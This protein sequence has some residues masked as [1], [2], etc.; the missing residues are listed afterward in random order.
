MAEHD[1]RKLFKLSELDDFRVAKGDPDIRGWRLVDGTHNPIG[2][3]KELIADP[4][5]ERVRYMD[6]V[7]DREF[8]KS[9]DE[10]H[11]LI[12]IGAAHVDE[13]DDKVIVDKV[14]REKLLAS[15]HYKGEAITRDFEHGLIDK[16]APGTK[17]L[18]SDEE[19]YSSEYFS[20]DRFYGP[21]RTRER[22][23]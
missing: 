6:V 11:V 20:T 21:R 18:A 17:K 3:V 7:L 16:I 5:A 15:P 19:F 23:R 8:W 1:E 4:R 14:D 22:I 9:D 10:R 2:N 12:P 13:E